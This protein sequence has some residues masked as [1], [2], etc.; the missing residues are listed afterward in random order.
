ML[1][2]LSFLPSYSA[3]FCSLSPSER[4]PL[5]MP[6][7]HVWGAHDPVRALPG[8]LGRPLAGP[9]GGCPP[10][11][12]VGCS[13]P[14]L[15]WSAAYRAGTSPASP[16]FLQS[17]NLLG[18]SCLSWFCTCPIP[19][20]ASPRCTPDFPHLS[21]ALRKEGT[22]PEERNF[23]ETPAGIIT[24]LKNSTYSVFLVQMTC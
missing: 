20:G 19:H 2:G 3:C 5:G 4:A 10:L 18:K 11:Q 17:W 8:G 16:R 22:H 23:L 13:G 1:H 9:S 24:D 21:S 7:L 14:S 12:L 15:G 6:S